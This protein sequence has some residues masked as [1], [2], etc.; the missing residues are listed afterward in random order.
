MS[1]LF[2]RH[3]APDNEDTDDDDNQVD[4]ALRL[5]T[6][7]TAHSTIAES[8]RSETR[9]TERRR[10]SR[11]WQTKG[12]FKKSRLHTAEDDLPRPTEP[13]E[14]PRPD[15]PESSKRRSIYVNQPLP[16]D[17]QDQHG[18]PQITY[19]RNKVRTTSKHQ[20]MTPYGHTLNTS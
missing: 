14:P 2:K 10:K 16:L 1:S 19:V 5:R 12:I 13:V 6:V 3:Q 8:I 15:L 7:R 9:R 11:K 20:S 18:D 17:Q 4:P